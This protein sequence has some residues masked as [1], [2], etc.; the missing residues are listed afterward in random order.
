MP[1]SGAQTDGQ[2]ANPGLV[3]KEEQGLACSQGGQG[4]P[5]AASWPPP[6]T[7]LPCS[8]VPAPP[9]SKP[10]LCMSSVVIVSTMAAVD[11]YLMEL[12]AGV[13]RASVLALALAGDLCF[14]L[15]LRYVGVWVGAEAQTPRRGV[16]L[17]FL[18]V[19]TLEIKLYFI[20]QGYRADRRAPDLLARRTLTLL[21]SV[22]I[23]SLYVVLVAT[24]H[25]EHVA[26]FRCKEDLRG[27][28]LWVVVDMLDLLEMQASLW[29]LQQQGL[30]LWAEGLTFFYCYSLLL[31]LPCV[32]LGE[33]GLPA[34]ARL[35]LYP[36]LSLLA[37]NLATLAI[38]AADLLLYRDQRVSAIF[39]AKNLLAIALKGCT[40]LQHHREGAA[41]LGEPLPG[42]TSQASQRGNGQHLWAQVHAPGVLSTQG[43]WHT[44]SRAGGT[45][46]ETTEPDPQLALAGII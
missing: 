25:L 44:C 26:A 8:A 29:E 27:R 6:A 35:P 24:E 34:P 38:R 10:H 3:Q 23:P 17:W 5:G 13:Q 22:C 37:V 41:G 46:P 19:F 43:P 14:L 33:M 12:S 36:L 4:C 31:V 1:G 15:V 32:A 30:P 11:V 21:L 2:S 40:V 45:V 16:A 20:Y 28:L 7:H 39:M 42:A 9:T 18:F